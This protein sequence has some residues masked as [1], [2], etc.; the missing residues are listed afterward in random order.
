MNK[1]LRQQI[2]QGMKYVPR[3]GRSWRYIPLNQMPK[4]TEI[5]VHTTNKVIPAELADPRKEPESDVIT[6]PEAKYIIKVTDWPTVK[7]IYSNEKSEFVTP[8]FR[9][10][11]PT[12]NFT[13]NVDRINTKFTPF[14]KEHWSKTFRL[15][16]GAISAIIIPDTHF[17][18]RDTDTNQHP[19][20]HR[21]YK[22]HTPLRKKWPEKT[23]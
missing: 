10:I 11:A 15:T 21:R 17:V 9:L 13:A 3:F 6:L 14:S 2:K 4:D 23:N 18:L 1:H 20:K 8:L 7:L 12:S 19:R 5:I 16:S 22:Y